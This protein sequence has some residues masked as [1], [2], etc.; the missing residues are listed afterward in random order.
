MV[1]RMSPQRFFA[2]VPNQGNLETTETPAYVPQSYIAV[3]G[4]SPPDD[5]AFKYIVIIGVVIIS[6]AALKYILKD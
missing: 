4:A 1:Q 5:Q 6:I 2:T 3:E